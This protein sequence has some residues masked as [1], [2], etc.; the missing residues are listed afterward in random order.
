MTRLTCKDK[1]AIDAVNGGLVDIHAPALG[2]PSNDF[3]ARLLSARTNVNESKSSI[4]PHKDEYIPYNGLNLL[5]TLPSHINSRQE[6][7]DVDN[8]THGRTLKRAR[9]VSVPGRLEREWRYHVQSTDDASHS[10]QSDETQQD[11]QPVSLLPS[12]MGPANTLDQ[13]AG[14]DIL[15]DGREHLK[16][17]IRVSLDDISFDQPHSPYSH[18]Y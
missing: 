16:M 4:K 14:P 5:D 11:A 15:S 3:C 9:S 13:G 6:S 10:K 8:V 7:N 2:N 12:T 17:L 1:S 18:P